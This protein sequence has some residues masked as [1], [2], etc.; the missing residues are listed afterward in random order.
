M[1]IKVN[2][3]LINA[4]SPTR[5]PLEHGFTITDR[6]GKVIHVLDDGFYL[7]EFKELLINKMI[8]IDKKKKMAKVPL[9]WYVHERDLTIIT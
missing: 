5:N 7:I 2:S 4:H 9:Q 1:N 6:T 8:T 3:S